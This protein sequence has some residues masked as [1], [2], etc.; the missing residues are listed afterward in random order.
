MAF[1]I[2][3]TNS[4]YASTQY[5]IDIEGVIYGLRYDYNNRMQTW[6]IQIKDSQG[7]ILIGGVPIQHG[8]DLFLQYKGIST[9]PQGSFVPLDESGQA[10]NPQ[11]DDLGNDVILFYEES[12][13]A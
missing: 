10:R 5:I 4:N 2:I 6:I 7:N 3:P 12:S 8:W 13:S 11:R 1:L 9:I